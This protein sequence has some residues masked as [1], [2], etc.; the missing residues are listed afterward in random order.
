MNRNEADTVLAYLVSAYSAN[1]EEGTIRVWHEKL[2]EMRAD[3][4]LAAARK[5]TS[6]GSIFMPRPGEFRVAYLAELRRDLGER[7]LPSGNR[8]V[9]QEE[10]LARIA[11]ARAVLQAKARP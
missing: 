11:E 6:S 2:A 10:G 9:S 8:P 7:G 1:P 4:A 5:L 3:L